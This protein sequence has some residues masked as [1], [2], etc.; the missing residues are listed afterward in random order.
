MSK[1]SVNLLR[2]MSQAFKMKGIGLSHSVITT[3]ST[4]TQAFDFN[5]AK[6]NV[7][8]VNTGVAGDGGGA[9]N[10]AIQGF[11]G[12][13]AG[14]VIYLVKTGSHN[15]LTLENQEGVSGV[16][17]FVCPAGAD[18]VISGSGGA[19]LVCD[20][21]VWNVISITSSAEQM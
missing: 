15:T 12:G 1:R 11:T 8:I 3:A 4:R 13:T 14:Q 21:S 9:V 19:T 6:A 10:A 2:S 20:G 5:V 17:N 7:V 18:A 16:Q